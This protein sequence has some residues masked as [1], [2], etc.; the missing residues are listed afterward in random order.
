MLSHELLADLVVNL[1]LELSQ[2]VLIVID[3]LC[4]KLVLPLPVRLKTIL[5]DLYLLLVLLELCDLVT[6]ELNHRDWSLVVEA[7]TEEF[8]SSE[9][10]WQVFESWSDFVPDLCDHACLV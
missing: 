8:N 4:E 6:D 3:F 9:T 2:Q 1:H 10:S 5:L 7:M